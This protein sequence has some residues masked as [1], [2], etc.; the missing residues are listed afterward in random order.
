MTGEPFERKPSTSSGELPPTHTVAPKVSMSR[1]DRRSGKAAV[2]HD[3]SGTRAGD[4]AA[5]GLATAGGRGGGGGAASPALHHG[6]VD[7][8]GRVGGGD[9]QQAHVLRGDGRG[10]RV[11]PGSEPYGRG[12]KAEREAGRV[13]RPAP[14]QAHDQA[15]RERVERASG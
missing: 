14:R 7:A 5:A 13:G 4:G 12:R 15:L 3:G 2:P 11:F 8:G 6:E 9:V 1:P 10:H